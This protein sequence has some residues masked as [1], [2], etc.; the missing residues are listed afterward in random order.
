MP[1]VPAVFKR[2][3]IFLTTLMTN[4]W[5]LIAVSKS[6]FQQLAGGLIVRI[7]DDPDFYPRVEG[8][9][10]PNDAGSMFIFYEYAEPPRLENI[11]GI[12][13]DES[14]LVGINHPHGITHKGPGKG[15]S[16]DSLGIRA[17]VA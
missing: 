9:D 3:V 15:L 16:V 14:V 7:I 10:F 13:Y 17:N 1:T 2:R 12:A 4:P 5:R 8:R 6:V 11:P